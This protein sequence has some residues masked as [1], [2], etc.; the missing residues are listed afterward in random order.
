MASITLYAILIPFKLICDVRMEKLEGINKSCCQSNLSQTSD[1]VVDPFGT[2]Q[3][4]RIS[5]STNEKSIARQMCERS[6][7]MTMLSVNPIDNSREL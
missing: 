7:G 1:E 5:A 3:G 6:R 2:L 4:P